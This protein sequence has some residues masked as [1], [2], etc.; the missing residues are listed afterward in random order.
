MSEFLYDALLS[1]FHVD[2]QDRSDEQLARLLCRLYD[3]CMV[4]HDYAG[5]SKLLSTRKAV[6]SA[7]AEARRQLQVDMHSEDEEDDGDEGEDGDEFDEDDEREAKQY[8]D[9]LDR[10]IASLS[11]TFPAEAKSDE[12]EQRTAPDPPEEDDGWTTVSSAKRKP[13]GKGT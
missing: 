11:V 9:D 13:K 1:S 6:H 10:G 7:R 3:D 5:L 4:R 2:A 8:G 12:A